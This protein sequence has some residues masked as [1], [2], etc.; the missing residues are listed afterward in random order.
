[1]SITEVRSF[2]GLISLK[3]DFGH[4]Y[5]NREMNLFQSKQCNFDLVTFK[6]KEQILG[7]LPILPIAAIVLSLGLTV[8]NNNSNNDQQHKFGSN[9]SWREKPKVKICGSEVIILGPKK[10]E[11]TIVIAV[12]V[13]WF[14]IRWPYDMRCQN[15]F[16]GTWELPVLHP[17]PNK[18]VP[19]SSISGF[20]FLPIFNRIRMIKAE[21]MEESTWHTLNPSCDWVSHGD[22]NGNVQVHV[23]ASLSI[24]RLRSLHDLWTQLLWKCVE[25]DALEK[26]RNILG[27]CEWFIPPQTWAIFGL[28]L[29][30]I[31]VQR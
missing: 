7:L 10:E 31:T 17:W 14:I 16:T 20:M 27:M 3:I 12:I 23:T 28:L 4:G 22:H 19:F 18:W 11:I 5:F 25:A 9:I 13:K 15:S 2:I 30:V 6:S 1:M 21:L 29:A 8:K 26:K 24:R